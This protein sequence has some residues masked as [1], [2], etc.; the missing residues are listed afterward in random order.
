ML[1]ALVARWATFFAPTLRVAAA[2]VQRTAAAG[3]AHWTTFSTAP[4]AAAMAHWNTCFPM[5]SWTP[6]MDLWTFPTAPRAAAIVPWI[7][8]HTA[9]WATAM[10]PWTTFPTAPWTAAGQRRARR[11]VSAAGKQEGVFETT[12]EYRAESCK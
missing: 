5:A 4:W 1:A 2:T 8:F 7:T 6:A 11:H 12:H 9:T 3:M 10:D